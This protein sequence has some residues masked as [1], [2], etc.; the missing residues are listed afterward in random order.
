[1]TMGNWGIFGDLERLRRDLNRFTERA[2]E[3]DSS[4]SPAVDIFEQEGALVLLLDL[5]GISREVIDLRVDADS[6]T[7]RGERPLPAEG[8]LLRSERPA[9]KFR[10]SFRIGVPVNPAGVQAVYRD[11][12]LRVTIPRAL[13]TEPAKVEITIE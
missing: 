7:I 2:R 5:P 13:P 1:M 9:G 8:N 3:D 12:V 10:R 4:W 6:I 11:G